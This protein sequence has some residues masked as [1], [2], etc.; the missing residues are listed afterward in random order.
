LRGARAGA[1][2]TLA[3]ILR[4]P[5]ASTAATRRRHGLEL[6][7]RGDDDLLQLRTSGDA[8]LE[9]WSARATRAVRAA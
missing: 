6:H 1:V 8:E 4:S 9:L 7:D 3:A 2:R 5:R